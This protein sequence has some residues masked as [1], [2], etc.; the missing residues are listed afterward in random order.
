LPLIKPLLLLWGTEY[1]SGMRWL[2]LGLRIH[3]NLL[4]YA[5]PANC[6]I[7]AA[8]PAIIIALIDNLRQKSKQSGRQKYLSF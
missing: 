6:P 4:T 8:S 2:L 3:S 1:P 7:Y 5:Q